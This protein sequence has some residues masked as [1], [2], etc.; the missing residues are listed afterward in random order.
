MH[1]AFNLAADLQGVTAHAGRVQEVGAG[2]GQLLPVAVVLVLLVR[3]DD[4]ERARRRQCIGLLQRVAARVD[5]RFQ[6]L[7]LSLA[8]MQALLDEARAEPD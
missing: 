1:V 6:R 8:R 5:Q 4:L 3:A 7:A 2:A